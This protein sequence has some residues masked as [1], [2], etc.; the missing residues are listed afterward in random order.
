VGGQIYECKADTAG[1]TNWVLR[2][3]VATLIRDGKTI[4]HHYAGPTWKLTEGD[5][6]QGKAEATAP[7]ATPRDV[8]LLKLD[9]VGH[10]GSGIL[11]DAK[12]VLRL[13][14]H[15]GVLKGAC[16][17]AGEVRAQPYSADYTFLR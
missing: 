9:V 5:A 7:G 10:R 4:G 1:S 16:P 11:S 15:G 2:E 14:T 3:P 13:N 6:V 17:K 12:L 8:A